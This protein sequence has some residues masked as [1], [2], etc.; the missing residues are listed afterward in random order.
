MGSDQHYP[1]EMPAHHV[2][3]EGFWIDRTPVTNAQFKRFVRAT[4]HVTFAEK[5]PDAKNYP[6][7]L[8]H[9]IFAGSLVF[10]PPRHPVDLRDW[11]QW[12]R[13]TRGANWRHPYGPKSNIH[14]LDH[15]PVVH[16]TYADALAYAEWAD[17]ILPTEAEW[18]FAARGGFEGTEFA[19]G[20]EMTPGGIHMANTWQGA[21]PSQNLLDDGY[22][23][24]SPVT[25]YPPNKYGIHDMI[26][27]VWEWTS[28]WYAAKHQS[29]APKTCCVP[30][31][32]RSAPEEA[33]YDPG[34]PEIR[35]PR[36]VIKGGSHLCAPNYCR[37]Y[38]PAARHAEPI[39]T[40]TSHVGFRCIVRQRKRHAEQRR[41]K[42]ARHKHAGT[43]SP[44]C[45]ARK[46]DAHR[47]RGCRKQFNKGTAAVRARCIAD[48]WQ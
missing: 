45:S 8:P 14:G 11:S 20:D 22:E 34:M 1:E 33:S 37:R 19:W 12:W 31:S 47:C 24:T 36:K 5:K 9:L 6:N 46:H 48:Q 21:F 40:S 35:I 42:D 13:L 29:D 44:E 10:S 28:D 32:P 7:A 25:A 15:H 27:N 30:A 16:V 38:R 39:D 23:R 18:E 4:S 2:S 3:V 26:G 43:Q 17:K 41:R